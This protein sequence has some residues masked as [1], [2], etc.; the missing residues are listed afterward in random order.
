[1]TQETTEEVEM[2]FEVDGIQYIHPDARPYLERFDATF[3]ARP[4]AEFIDDLED[5]E[6]HMDFNEVTPR[7]FIWYGP[8]TTK[9]L[10]DD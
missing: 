10:M 3:N 1:M 7:S 5:F 2:I 4:M 6:E 9:G 8:P